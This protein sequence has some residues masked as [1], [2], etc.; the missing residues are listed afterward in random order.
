MPLINTF[1]NEQLALKRVKCYYGLLKTIEFSLRLF[2]TVVK[3]IKVQINAI[4]FIF[5]EAEIRTFEI[6]ITV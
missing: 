4:K 2:E 3:T 6:R 5:N 1:Y